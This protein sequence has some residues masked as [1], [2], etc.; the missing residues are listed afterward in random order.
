MSHRV[1]QR[2]EVNV[3]CLIGL[4]LL[5]IAIFIAYKMVPV[6]VRAADL[7]QTIEDEA[8]S[9]GTHSDDRITQAIVDKAREQDLPVKP[10]DVKI[11]RE[12]G[13]ITVDVEYT[14]PIEFPGYLYPWHQHIVAENP[15]F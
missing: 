8:K 12:H 4:V 7:K 14:V 2:G 15:I 10:E 9:A 5:A 6:K 11:K 3:G 1:R 13:S